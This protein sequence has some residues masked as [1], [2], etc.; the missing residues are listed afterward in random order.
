MQKNKVHAYEGNSNRGGK[1]NNKQKMNLERMIAHGL[2]Q[3]KVSKVE[4]R[5]I[6]CYLNNVQT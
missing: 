2:G 1:S 3:W 6:V 4:A 5:T